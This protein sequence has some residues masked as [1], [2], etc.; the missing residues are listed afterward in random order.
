MTAKQETATKGGDERRN[1][2]RQTLMLFGIG[3]D[4]FAS[5]TRKYRHA[6]ASIKDI[7]KRLYTTG[8]T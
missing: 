6:Q 1:R 8:V 4:V 2:T 7:V 3:V 5:E